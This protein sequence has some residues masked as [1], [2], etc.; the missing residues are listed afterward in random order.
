MVNERNCETVEEEECSMVR[1]TKY[2]C[3]MVSL[4]EKKIIFFRVLFKFYKVFS[5]NSLKGKKSIFY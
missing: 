1:F 5:L 2:F 4:K 3:S